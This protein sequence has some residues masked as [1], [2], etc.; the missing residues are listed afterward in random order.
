MHFLLFF[1]Y[2]QRAMQPK[3]QRND[4]NYE[5]SPIFSRPSHCLMSDLSFRSVKPDF[6]QPDR[7]FGSL[8]RDVLRLVLSYICEGDLSDYN[9][10][11]DGASNCSPKHYWWTRYRLLLVNK[12]WN[13]VVHE[14]FLPLWTKLDLFRDMRLD[15]VYQSIKGINAFSFS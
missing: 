1:A 8:N 10:I 15:L 5:E 14:F 9:T 6:I 11:G 7:N 4:T 2:S 12:H 3:R 13:E